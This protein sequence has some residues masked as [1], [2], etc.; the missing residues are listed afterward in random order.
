[1]FYN[2]LHVKLYGVLFS[3]YYANNTALLNGYYSKKYENSDGRFA[4]EYD[5]VRV[6]VNERL[7]RYAD[8]LMMGCRMP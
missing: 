6:G 1:M 8:V 3:Q 7:M 2:A 5:G 4:N